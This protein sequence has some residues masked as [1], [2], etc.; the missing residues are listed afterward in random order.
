MDC[1]ASPAQLCCSWLSVGDGRGG[2]E[3]LGM[4]PCMWEV[5][6]L[7]SCS[8]PSAISQC[9]PQGIPD[10][11]GLWKQGR[12]RTLRSFPKLNFLWLG[13]LPFFP[14]I[15]LGFGLSCVDVPRLWCPSDLTKD[16]RQQRRGVLSPLEV[17]CWNFPLCA[18][19][20][21]EQGLCLRS[22]TGST[23]AAFV[24]SSCA[25]LPWRRQRFPGVDALR[26][27]LSHPSE[28]PF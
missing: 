4:K 23:P 25:A 7:Y 9:S 8:L 26:K 28:P 15:S 10:P 17:K 19:G 24:F 3:L 13:M 22:Q 6:V 2:S 1:G 12:P 20:V 21:A 14:W 16:W 27:E 11:S 18:A 5:A